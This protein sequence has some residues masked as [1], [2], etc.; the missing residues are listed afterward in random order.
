MR[1]Y[2]RKYFACTH[3]HSLYLH[4]PTYT[5]MYTSIHIYVYIYIYIY[6]NIYVCIYIYIYIDIYMCIFI[7]PHTHIYPYKCMYTYI[8]IY[9]PP[10]TKDHWLGIDLSNRPG[11]YSQRSVTKPFYYSKLSR[12]QTFRKKLPEETRR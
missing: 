3:K 5:Y 7:Y 8:Y 12:E 4:P 6:V 9:A 2:V 11:G 1:T 10:N